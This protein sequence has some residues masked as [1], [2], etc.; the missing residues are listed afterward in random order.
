MGRTACAE[1]Q[2]LYKGALYLTYFHIQNQ[3]N[4]PYNE[5]FVCCEVETQVK[6]FCH[7]KFALQSVQVWQPISE[8]F[9]DRLYKVQLFNRDILFVTV[10]EC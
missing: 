9:S 1:P 2:C 5:Q 3:R 6:T 10:I 8:H 4:G 7:P